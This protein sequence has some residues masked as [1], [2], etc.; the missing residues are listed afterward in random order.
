MAWMALSSGLL[1]L[2]ELFGW[3]E[4]HPASVNQSFYR[5]CWRLCRRSNR[6]VS[7]IAHSAC[8]GQRYRYTFLEL[9]LWTVASRLTSVPTNRKLSRQTRFALLLPACRLLAANSVN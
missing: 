9:R 5:R 7:A 1:L 2:I 4:L 8:A 6:L 3:A